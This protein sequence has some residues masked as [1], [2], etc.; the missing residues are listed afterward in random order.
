MKMEGI[1]RWQRAVNPDTSV[2][3]SSVE[4][5]QGDPAPQL[6]GRHSA[7]LAMCWD[8]YSREELEAKIARTK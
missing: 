6:Q 7:L 8:H 1:I 5:R 2:V 4:E 3:Y